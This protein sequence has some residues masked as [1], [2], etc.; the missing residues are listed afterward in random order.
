M[1]SRIIYLHGFASSPQSRK[2]QFFRQKFAEHGITLEIPELANQGFENLTISGQLD[3]IEKAANGEPVSVMGS[4]MGGYLAA[5]Y[6]SRHPETKS[7]V[8]L[9]PAFEFAHRWGDRIGEDAMNDWRRTGF[10]DVHHYGDGKPAR[11]SYNLIADALK[12]PGNPAFSQPALIFHGTQDDIVPMEVSIQYAATH[13]NVSLQL[14][15]DGHELAAV[16]QEM[17]NPLPE[18]FN[19]S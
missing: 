9:A 14:F 10:L 17:W 13:S 6:A 8:L 18:F 3:V 5:L 11:V 4:S 7:V 2:A 12:Y 1:T 19:F 16:F 15:E